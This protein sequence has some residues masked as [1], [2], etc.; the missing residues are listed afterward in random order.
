L[1]R[2]SRNTLNEALME[3]GFE[4]TIMK[5]V[6]GMGLRADFNVERCVN[7]LLENTFQKVVLKK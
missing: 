2:K 1:K 6:N 3:E 4:H 5:I 7:L